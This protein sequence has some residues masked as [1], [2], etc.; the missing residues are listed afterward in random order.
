[1]QNK[2]KQNNEKQ[3][4]IKPKQNKTKQNKTKQKITCADP[5]PPIKERNKSNWGIAIA[6]PTEIKTTIAR[7]NIDLIKNF[8]FG[9]RCGQHIG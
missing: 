2:Q 7:S 8:P 5:S 6:K 3:S 1:L 9:R 4:Q